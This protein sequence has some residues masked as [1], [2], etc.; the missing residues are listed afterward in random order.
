MAFHFFNTTI[1]QERYEPQLTVRVILQMQFSCRLAVD[2]KMMMMMMM[3]DYQISIAN[4]PLPSLPRV[5][6]SAGVG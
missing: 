5:M 4:S 3:N 1:N 2:D 6:A